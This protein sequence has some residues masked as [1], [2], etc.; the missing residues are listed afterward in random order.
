MNSCRLTTLLL[1]VQHWTVADVF[2]AVV[3][4]PVER[5]LPDR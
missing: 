1:F 4:V 5:E 2:F 3:L